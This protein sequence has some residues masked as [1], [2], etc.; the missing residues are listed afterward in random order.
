MVKINPLIFRE[1]DIRGF[2]GKELNDDFAYCL[3]RAFAQLIQ[4]SNLDNIGIGYDCRHSSKGFAHALARGISDMGST[5]TIIGMCPS[6]VLYYSIIKR[7]FGGGIQ[8]TGSHNP[9]DMNGFKLSVGSH[10][11]SGREIQDLRIKMEKIQNEDLPIGKKGKIQEENSIPQ[12]VAEIIANSKPHLGDRK[13]KVVVDAGNGVGGMT[14]V[15]VLKGLGV[16]TIE[17]FCD[18]D[19]DFP[20][21]HPDPT[22]IKYLT[23]L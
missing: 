12:Y 9:S 14:G 8:V 18:P 13:L 4:E 7:N 3:G 11:L 10:S 1:Y 16:E 20:N 17:L 5:A 6:P 19:G 22:V 15:S 21:H 2:V 23:H